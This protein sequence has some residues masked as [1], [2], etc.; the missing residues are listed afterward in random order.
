[1][2]DLQGAIRKE[3][4]ARRLSQEQ[5]GALVGVSGSSIGSYEAERLVP[6]PAIAKALDGVF[7][8]GDRIQRLA[9][10]ARGLSVAPFLRSWAENE[11]QASMLR[12]FQL[13]VV[14]GLLQ[15]E[16]YA[17]HVLTD[18]GPVDDVETSLASRLAR[19]EVVHAAPPAVMTPPHSCARPG[20]PRT[21]PP[22]PGRS[23]GT[24]VCAGPPVVMHCSIDGQP[25]C[26]RYHREGRT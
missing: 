11:A 8:T 1:M 2:I 22:R 6:V 7:E 18:V 12:S 19:Q 20:T 5:L 23:L 9:A 14:P 26:R 10:Q 16:A 3:R 13:S 25:P 21:G 4:T 24:T 17:R 15:T